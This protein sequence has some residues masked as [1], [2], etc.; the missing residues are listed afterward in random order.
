MM[1]TAELKGLHE[2]ALAKF[3]EAKAQLAEQMV[4]VNTCVKIIQETEEI[5]NKREGV[6]N[7]QQQ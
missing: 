5:I 2:E 3:E 4:Y 1:T 7:V 6:K